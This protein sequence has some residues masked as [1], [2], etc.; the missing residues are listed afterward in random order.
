L[1]PV[2]SKGQ[3]DAE[4]AVVVIPLVPVA[5]DGESVTPFATTVIA[6]PV[7]AHN[8]SVRELEVLT[9]VA[10]GLSD[11]QVA[12][13]LGISPKTVRNHLGQVFAKLGAGNR[14]EAV[15]NALKV[16]LLNL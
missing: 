7:A 3:P 6:R 4:G 11:K 15:I 10:A 13:K 2:I 12:G 1:G 9:N 16:G 5:E 14:V 8:L